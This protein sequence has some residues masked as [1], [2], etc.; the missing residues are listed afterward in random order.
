MPSTQRHLRRR[1]CPFRERPRDE[2]SRLRLAG[3]ASAPR[4]E[5][6]WSVG[7]CRPR[8]RP[9]APC[10]SGNGQ[11][12][13]QERRRQAGEPAAPQAATSP[14]VGAAPRRHARLSRL[15]QART[16]PVVFLKP[17]CRSDRRALAKGGTGTVHSSTHCSIPRPPTVPLSRPPSC[18]PPSCPG[19]ASLS[20]LLL[21]VF[22][23]RSVFMNI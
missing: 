7:I 23:P 18:P 10:I 11:Q 19:T 1:S 3:V 20:A 16:P 17:S 15:P 6:K 2:A 14:P 21:S 13:G 22:H 9:G 12:V 5:A 8:W 4:S